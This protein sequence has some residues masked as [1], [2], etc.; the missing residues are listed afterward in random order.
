MILIVSKGDKLKNIFTAAD[1]YNK[2]ENL[3]IQKGWTIYGL[4]KRA[5]V[6]NSTI[7]NWRDNKSSPNI[8][9]LRRICN[10]L[11]ISAAKLF[12]NDMNYLSLGDE[13]R[14]LISCFDTLE[15]DMQTAF[16]N[17]IKEMAKK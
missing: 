5:K 13:Q 12:T 9:M 10:A 8:N 14:E 6:A 1:I 4:A 2:V 15:K 17:L 7:Y 3:M 16:L 11:N